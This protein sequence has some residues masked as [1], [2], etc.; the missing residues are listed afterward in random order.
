MRR[1]RPSLRHALP[2]LAL[3]FV[4]PACRPSTNA[5]AVVL[6]GEN[7]AVSVHVEV[8]RTHQELSRGLMWRDRLGAYEGMLFVFD[9]P[10][11]RTFWMKNTPLSLDILFIDDRGRIAN[12]AESTTPYS[13]TPIRS[14]QP[15]RYVLEVNAGFTRRHGIHAGARADL[16]A[17]V[18][19]TASHP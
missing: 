15:V 10:S 4:L 13:E 14:A 17:I 5:P 6:T 11:D 9:E 12:I 8:A 19:E 16:S 2:L 7:G 1:R 18:P 3:L